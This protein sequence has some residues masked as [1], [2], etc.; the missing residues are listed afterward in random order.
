MTRITNHRYVLAVKDLA[1]STNYYNHT[2]G[3]KPYFEGGGWA[4]VKRDHCI[5]MLG[6]CP[7]SPEARELPNHNYFAYVEVADAQVVYDEFSAKGAT[8]LTK[9]TPKPW[10]MKEFALET[11]DG[12]RLMFAQEIS[13]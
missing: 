6:E 12:H 7:D 11:I 2:L 10:G 8:L 1:R 4:F 13:G 9:L 3:F 5:I